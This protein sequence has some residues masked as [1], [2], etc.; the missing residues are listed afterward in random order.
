[1]SALPLELDWVFEALANGHRREI[2][3]SLSL[4][5]YTIKQLANLRQLSL[6]AIHKHIK[7]L[8][9]AGLIVRKKVGRSNFLALKKESL[10][11]LQ[12]WL[13]QFAAYWGSDKETLENYVNFLTKESKKN[14]INPK[15]KK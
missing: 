2:I 8:E 1:M 7:I 4:Q 9:L 13:N 10:F 5:P 3:Y 15:E 12:K 6:P 11:G 14:K